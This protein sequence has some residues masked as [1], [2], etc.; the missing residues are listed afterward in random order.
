MRSRGGSGSLLLGMM[1]ALCAGVTAADETDIVLADGP[2][3]DKVQAFCSMCHSLDYIVMNS[4]FQD[5]VAWEKSVRKMVT[6]M[7]A[8][9]TAEEIVAIVAYLDGHYGKQLSAVAPH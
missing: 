3:R 9:L 4:P 5:K 1:L 7:G 8:P 6:V 2:G